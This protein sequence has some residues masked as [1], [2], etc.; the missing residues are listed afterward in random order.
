MRFWK[1]AFYLWFSGDFGGCWGGE[2]RRR[3]GP[4]GTWTYDLN[5]TLKWCGKWFDFNHMTFSFPVLFFGHISERGEFPWR[6]IGWA[7]KCRVHLENLHENY[8]ILCVIYSPLIFSAIISVER[9]QLDHTKPCGIKDLYLSWPFGN[10][11]SLRK[12]YAQKYTSVKILL[13]FLQ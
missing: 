11:V 12:R 10:S 2:I 5:T 8:C 6:Q 13:H 9:L 3:R 4:L 1:K 7:Q